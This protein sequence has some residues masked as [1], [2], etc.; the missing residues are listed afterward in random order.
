M[1]RTYLI[2]PKG[3]LVLEV[4]QTIIGRRR[5]RRWRRSGAAA[6]AASPLHSWIRVADGPS[7]LLLL[8]LLW[9]VVAGTGD[10]NRLH[11]HLTLVLLG[12]ILGKGHDGGGGCQG[13]A[14]GDSA[15]ACKRSFSFVVSSSQYPDWKKS[16]NSPMPMKKRS[17]S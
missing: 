15:V 10:V 4:Q 8:L 6:A 7:I 3:P 5:R 11:H 16:I 17:A 12:H 13:F 9:L 1:T 14:V 2:E